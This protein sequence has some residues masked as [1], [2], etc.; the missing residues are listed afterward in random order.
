MGELVLALE[1]V[2]IGAYF[3]TINLFRWFQATM[4]LLFFFAGLVS[5]QIPPYQH[6]GPDDRK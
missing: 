5:S 4:K 2:F 3:S 1:S 6:P